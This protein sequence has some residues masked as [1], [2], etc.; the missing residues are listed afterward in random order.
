MIQ[1]KYGLEISVLDGLERG[2]SDE[3]ISFGYGTGGCSGRSIVVVCVMSDGIGE[4]LVGG[5]EDR[6]TGLV[7]PCRAY[8]G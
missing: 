8:Q 1:K 2:V 6:R 7:V 3:K 4:H 5:G